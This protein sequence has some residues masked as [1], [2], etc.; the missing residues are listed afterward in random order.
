[1]VDDVEVSSHQLVLQVC[2]IGNLNL[3]A[4]VGDNDASS[5]E[6]DAFAERDVSRDGKVVELGDVWNRLESLFEVRN[7]LEVVAELDNGRSTKLSGLVHGQDSV[8][9]V[10]KFR[11][12]QEQVRAR[13]DWQETGS[14]NV[15]TNGR[16]KV[17]DSGT[18]GSLELDDSLTLVGDLV[19]DNDLQAQ[20][21]V[22]HDTLDCAEVAPDVVGVE[23]LELPGGAELVQVVLGHLRDLKQPCLALVVDNGTTLDIR[24]GL[25]GDFHDVL[26]LSVDHGLEDVEVDDGTQVVDVGDEDVL[27]AG[28]NE[29]LEETGVGKGIKDISVSGWVPSPCRTR[30]LVERATKTPC[31]LVGIETG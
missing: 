11:L 18:N 24:L 6:T 23:D 10:V 7:L 27:F 5:S 16:V 20:C 9:Q 29:L 21:V 2:S 30:P 1:V 15:D 4:L 22:I 26:G 12:D 25:V 14:G 17:L 19:V 8:F 31:Q 3:V 28:G 13:L